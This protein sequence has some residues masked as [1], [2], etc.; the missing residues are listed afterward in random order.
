MGLWK[1]MGVRARA[2]N[3]EAI[4]AIRHNEVLLR[5]NLAAS[6]DTLQREF[7]WAAPSSTE[8]A[9]CGA[10]PDE[11]EEMERDME[12]AWGRLNEPD[13]AFDTWVDEECR[14]QR[15]APDPMEDV[16]F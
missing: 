7:P 15:A 11:T 12:N 9:E 5:S 14:K 2:G 4:R 1:E 16:P 3:R 13:P 6:R 8:L 10:S